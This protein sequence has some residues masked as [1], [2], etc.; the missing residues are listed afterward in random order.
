MALELDIGANTRKFMAGVDDVGSALDEVAD[1]LDGLTRDTSRSAD[2]AG[3]DLATGIEGGADKAADSLGK[4]TDAAD[5]LASGVRSEADQAGK[6]LHNSIEDGAKSASKEL[7]LVERS[8]KDVARMARQVDPGKPLGQS[9]KKGTDEAKEGLGEFKDEAN[10]TAKES[11]ASFD[12]SAESIVDSFQEIA[13]N[14]FAGFGP[15]GAIAGLA[16]AAGIG[17]GVK[18]MEEGGEVSDALKEKIAALAGEYIDVGQSTRSLDQVSAALREMATSTEDGVDNFSDLKD[19]ADKS[20]Q[21]FDRI[22]LA[23][24]GNRDEL[25]KLTASTERAIEATEEQ[26]EATNSGSGGLLRAATAGERQRDSL[27]ELREKLDEARAAQDAA[28][29]A[30]DAYA[31][32]DDGLELK[33]QAAS[34]YASS[35]ADAYAEAGASIDKYVKDGVFNL[36]KYNEEAKAH[37]AAVSAYQQNMVTASQTLSDEALNYISS[38]GVEAAP[39]LDAFVKAPASKQGETAAIWSALGA[40][41]SNAFSSKVRNDLSGSNYGADVSLRPDMS[42]V[43]AELQRQRTITILARVQRIGDLPAIGGNPNRNGMGVP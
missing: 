35:V 20:D 32:A 14:A 7:V 5:D 23:L 31:Q 28:R 25:D 11:A 10:S 22:A 34:D 3:D 1:S 17:I 13:A 6:A 21:P 9:V 40:T 43:N 36:D 30:S 12:G 41:S 39:L 37:A 29:E 19:L 8:F 42:A 38:M 33:A 24:A 16:I 26:A 15:A 18:K 27:L 2:Q 4:I